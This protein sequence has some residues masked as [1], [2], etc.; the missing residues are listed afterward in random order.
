MNRLERAALLLRIV[1]RAREK[2]SLCGQTHLQKSTYFVQEIMRVPLGFDFILYRH[3]PFSFDL[4]DEFTALRA[5]HLLEFESVLP[6]GPKIAP[7][8]RKDYIHGVFS[9][10]LERYDENI[11]FISERLGAK[12]SVELDRLGTALYVTRLEE[13]EASVDERRKRMTEL[14]PHI[15]WESARAA[16]EEVDDIVASAAAHFAGGSRKAH[17]PADRVG[18]P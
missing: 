8:E 9:G 2:G 6:W 7:T 12:G 15:P 4:R 10:I 17:S 18:R 14:K 13:A 11:S 16:V 5:D 1:E 3:G